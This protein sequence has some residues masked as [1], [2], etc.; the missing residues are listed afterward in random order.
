MHY[1]R[2]TKTANSNRGIESCCRSTGWLKLLVDE[3]GGAAR[4]ILHEKMDIGAVPCRI[5]QPPTIARVN[6]NF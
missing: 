2:D 6:G 3:L 1:L 5:H 4:A